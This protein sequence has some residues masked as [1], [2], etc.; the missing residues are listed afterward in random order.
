VLARGNGWVSGIPGFG[1]NAFP[2]LAGE[3]RLEGL[4]RAA[5]GGG[6]PPKRAVFSVHTSREPLFFSGPAAYG[7]PGETEDAGGWQPRPG[8]GN[9]FQRLRGDDFL[10]VLVL[11]DG[12]E[13]GS[14][15]V[16][17]EFPGGIEALGMG[18]A[19]F[20]QFITAWSARFLYFLSLIKTPGD[21]SLPAVV[22]F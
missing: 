9:V 11:E 21:V 15:T 6:A 17:F 18:N 12:P 4:A 8:A 10:A 2:A 1:N 20:N 14:W 5:G 22:N 13:Q 7:Q 3:Y 16:I 19:G